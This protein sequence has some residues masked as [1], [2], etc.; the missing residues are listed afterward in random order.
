MSTDPLPFSPKPEAHRADKEYLRPEPADMAP[1]SKD[2]ETHQLG[3]KR[4]MS[5]MSRLMG[6]LA[7][8]EPEARPVWCIGVITLEKN[9]GIA[10]TRRY[11]KERLLKMPR[12]RSK[13][14]VHRWGGHFEEVPVDDGY[15]FEVACYGK[16]ATQDDLNEVVASINTWPFHADKPLWK[17]IHVPEF[18]D[19]TSVIIVCVNHA[20]GDG[21]ALVNVFV[22][23]CDIEE[24][25]KQRASHTGKRKTGPPVSVATKAKMA[26]Y[27]TYE[28]MFATMFRND[29]KNALKLQGSP[30][31]KKVVAA[32]PD[33]IALQ[34]IKD[35][36]AKVGD[37][38]TV[39]DVLMANYVRTLRAFFVEVGDERVVSG[40]RAVRSQFPVNV[41][42]RNEGPCN[43]EGDPNNRFGFGMITL[44]LDFKDSTELIRRIKHK[45]DEVKVS[46][47]PRLAYATL[48]GYMAT[49][50]R[51]VL[52][53]VL[54]DSVNISTAQL[55]N[56]PGPQVGVALAGAHVV[57]FSFFLFS[58][59]GLYFGV[60]SYNG[61]VSC[62]VNMDASIGQDP[63]QL[64]KHWGP[65]FEKMHAEIMG[66]AL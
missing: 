2:H 63:R 32:S 23:L 55:S 36:A 19:G 59:L 43:H 35:I 22:K 37:G 66:G 26:V 1:A 56:V 41:R 10:E 34:R 54:L 62:S 13:L 48:P 20:I 3:R 11:L 64:V 60:A 65:Q 40:K 15:H 51:P 17:V 25:L 4:R 39:N 47:A 21:V 42:K 16:R 28:A 31:P 58:T 27:G 12:F 44:P 57:R 18:I 6:H 61:E 5:S 52:L 24:D 45:I 7:Y 50:P 29:Y 49:L 14:V 33:V 8:S 38:V 30:S 46:P 53:K 9:P